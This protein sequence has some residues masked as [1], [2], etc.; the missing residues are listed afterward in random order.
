MPGR[1]ATSSTAVSAMSSICES[2]GS[3]TAV[4]DEMRRESGSSTG[5]RVH[6]SHMG[7]PRIRFCAHSTLAAAIAA[8]GERIACASSIHRGGTARPRSIRVAVRPSLISSAGPRARSRAT[9]PFFGPE[10]VRRFR[11]PRFASGSRYLISDFANEV[12]IRLLR[13]PP[14][15]RPW[16]ASGW[17]HLIGPVPTNGWRKDPGRAVIVV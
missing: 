1:P 15:G 17:L 10:R 5:P 2:H 7:A 8:L 11:S 16:F 6:A 13:L 14:G 4:T 3:C 9:G 12:R